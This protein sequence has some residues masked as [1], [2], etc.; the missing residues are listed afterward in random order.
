MLRINPELAPSLNPCV[1][2]IEPD[3]P[4]LIARRVLAVISAYD[5]HCG[6]EAW[7]Y[8]SQSWRIFCELGGDSQD[9]IA[10]KDL[11]RDVVWS[12]RALLDC[13]PPTVWWRE[14]EHLDRVTDAC[15]TAIEA[16]RTDIRR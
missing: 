6:G 8:F 15:N 11:M 5:M 7:H 12:A 1:D 3:R 9:P 10:V 4:I 14:P 13:Y 2:G 16:L